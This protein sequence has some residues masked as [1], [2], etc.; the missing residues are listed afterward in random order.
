MPWDLQRKIDRM[1]TVHMRH[2]DVSAYGYKKIIRWDFS[3][4]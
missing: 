3:P 1:A 2:D 4:A